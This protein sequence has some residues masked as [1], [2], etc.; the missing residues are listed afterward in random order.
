[1]VSILG[2]APSPAVEA[3]AQMLHLL[4]VG[5]AALLGGG[6]EVPGLVDPVDPLRDRLRAPSWT[7]TQ[8][9]EGIGLAQVCAPYCWQ[10]RNPRRMWSVVCSLAVTFLR[11]KE[12]SSRVVARHLCLSLQSNKD[13]RAAL[14]LRGARSFLTLPW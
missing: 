14:S 1:M 8:D 2:S 12:P 4:G 7:A 5:R 6:G 9:G 13:G 10:R 3:F 11:R